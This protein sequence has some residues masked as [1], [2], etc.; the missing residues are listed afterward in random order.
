MNLKKRIFILLITTIFT[1]NLSQSAAFLDYAKRLWK[2][3]EDDDSVSVATKIQIANI[4]LGTLMCAVCDKYSTN[5]LNIKNNFLI[6]VRPNLLFSSLIRIPRLCK[7]INDYYERNYN[8]I[9]AINDNDIETIQNIINSDPDMLDAIDSDGN[10]TLT[11]AITLG[12]VLMVNLLIKNGAN[13]TPEIIQHARQRVIN[14]REGQLILESLAKHQAMQV[15]ETN[16]VLDKK[17]LPEIRNI[18]CQYIK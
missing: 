1:F 17:L 8:I 9:R 2:L 18:I 5:K 6:N 13:I 14:N 16:I 12:N 4:P 7:Q 3:Y 11:L 10:Q 15:L